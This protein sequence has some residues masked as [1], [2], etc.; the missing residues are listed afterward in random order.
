MSLLIPHQLLHF[1]LGCVILSKTL[2]A[3]IE[4]KNWKEMRTSSGHPSM[5]IPVKVPGDSLQPLRDFIWVF[6][7]ARHHKKGVEIILR[8]SIS[9]R[10]KT[11]KKKAKG[12][13]IL[14]KF[15]AVFWYT[16]ESLLCHVI[17]DSLLSPSI[18]DLP[19]EF[20]SKILSLRKIEFWSLKMQSYR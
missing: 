15:K 10:I 18:K 17:H 8:Q 12:R 2:P 20:K 4:M 13:R 5:K 3:H 14:M 11:M 6:L 9:L 7:G 16:N 1:S 19:Q